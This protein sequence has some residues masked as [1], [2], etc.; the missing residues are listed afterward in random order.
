VGGHHNPDTGPAWFTTAYFHRPEELAGEVTDAGLVL[1]R[2][3]AV[4]SPP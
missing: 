4:E 1:E 2:I 3:V